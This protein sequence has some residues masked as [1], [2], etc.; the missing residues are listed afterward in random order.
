MT[1]PKDDK[2]EAKNPNAEKMCS[3]CYNK[4]KCEQSIFDQIFC[5]LNQINWEIKKSRTG[6]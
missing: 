3:M 1:E 5:K 2:I 6:G 4:D